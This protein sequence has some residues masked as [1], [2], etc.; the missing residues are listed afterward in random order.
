MLFQLYLHRLTQK[1]RRNSSSCNQD[2]LLCLLFVLLES[3]FDEFLIALDV[4]PSSNS[5]QELAPLT[6]GA[7]A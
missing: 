2:S 3:S 5:V 4:A 6:A 7:G 1:Y